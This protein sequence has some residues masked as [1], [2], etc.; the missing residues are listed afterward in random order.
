MTLNNFQQFY[1]EA[2]STIQPLFRLHSWLSTWSFSSVILGKQ[3]SSAELSA[4][5]WSRRSG[6]VVMYASEGHPLIL[7][8]Q[9]ML[10]L[11]QQISVHDSRALGTLGAEKWSFAGYYITGSRI[12]FTVTQTCGFRFIWTKLFEERFYARLLYTHLQLLDCVIWQWSFSF[13]IGTKAISIK[14]SFVHF[15]RQKDFF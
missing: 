3:N 5:P 14:G 7:K 8:N 11:P 9:N 4:S 6:D 1:L 2:T 15:K 10:E 13:K 12:Q